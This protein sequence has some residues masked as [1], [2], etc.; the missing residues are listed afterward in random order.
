MSAFRRAAHAAPVD[1]S[2]V[3][4][5]FSGLSFDPY[6]DPP[7]QVWVGFVH[8]TDEFVVVAEDEIEI[9]G[10]AARCVPGD[11]ALV[12]AGAAYSLR[13]WADAGSRW[14]YA[15]GSFGGRDE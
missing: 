12:P 15:D 5:D 11:L 1:G 6:V 3:R 13:T 7:G 10:E 9:A 8:D 4:A 2:A 14:F